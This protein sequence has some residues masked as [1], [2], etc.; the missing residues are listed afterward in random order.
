LIK[1]NLKVNKGNETNNNSIMNRKNEALNEEVK[2]IY[3]KIQKD[4]NLTGNLIK[5]FTKITIQEFALK[6]DFKQNLDDKILDDFTKALLGKIYAGV[7]LYL[8][9]FGVSHIDLILKRWVEQSINKEA[10]RRIESCKNQTTEKE[11]TNISQP[12][13]P[14]IIAGGMM[15]A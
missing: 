8:G 15:Y 1:I 10:Q 13:E 6:G 9:K 14:P 3:M 4:W 12:T 5:D 11:C 7:E 2:K